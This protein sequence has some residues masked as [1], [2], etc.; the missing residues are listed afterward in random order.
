[1]LGKISCDLAKKVAA[2]SVP[3]V[4]NAQPIRPLPN[5]RQKNDTIFSPLVYY[6]PDHKSLDYLS[7][8]EAE[9]Q[10]D[11]MIENESEMS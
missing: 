9:K 10:N 4:M 7:S 2:H 8:P 3:A 5:E 11:D 1:M 6:S